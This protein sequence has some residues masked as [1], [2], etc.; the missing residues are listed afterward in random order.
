MWE[1]LELLT[2]EVK[3]AWCSAP[4]R[5]CL[6]GVMAALQRVQCALRS[7]SKLHFGSVSA[8]LDTLRGRL[9][10]LRLNPDHSR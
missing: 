7:W 6:G 8:E 3:V 9:E 10:E 4:S 5:E 2:D 1:C